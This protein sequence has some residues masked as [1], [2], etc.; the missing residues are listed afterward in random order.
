MYAVCDRAFDEIPAKNDCNYCVYV[1]GSVQPYLYG[2][3]HNLANPFIQAATRHS[4]TYQ[5]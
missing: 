3:K 5:H 4:I 2:Y 1:Y